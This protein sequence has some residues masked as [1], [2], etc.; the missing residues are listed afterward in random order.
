MDPLDVTPTPVEAKTENQSADILQKT[1][2][3]V[4]LIQVSTFSLVDKDNKLE[5]EDKE[6]NKEIS[7]LK[8][9][10]VAKDAFI[11]KQIAE[12]QWFIFFKNIS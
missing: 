4:N 6:K 9:V 1:L 2:H 12:N 5:K 8:R 11:Q 3:N 10:I 7:R